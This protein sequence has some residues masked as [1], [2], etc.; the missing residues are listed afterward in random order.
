[1]TDRREDEAPQDVAALVGPQ[2]AALADALEAQPPE[3]GDRPSL[4][5]GWSVRAVLVHMTMANRYDEPSFQRQLEAAGHDF[6][7]LSDTIALRDAEL[8]WEEL[9]AGLRSDTMARWLPPG[10]GAPGAL[11]H[12]V[13]HGLDVT[14]ALDLPRSASDEAT[15]AVL[16]TLTT[17]G[18]HRRFGTDLTGRRLRATD[19]DWSHGD[20]EATEGAAGDLVLALAGRPRP[21]VDLHA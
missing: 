15:R 7:T 5:A 8:P 18:V 6:Q 17:G 11:S 19:L 3:V 14:A 12:V 4:C 16:E 1:M 10:G 21:G 13:I 20:G 2:F 9:L